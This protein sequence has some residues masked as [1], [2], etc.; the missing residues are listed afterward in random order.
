MGAGRAGFGGVKGLSLPAGPGASPSGSKLDN[1]QHHPARPPWRD[2][3]RALA[4]LLLLLSGATGWMYGAGGPPAD[5]GPARTGGPIV[6]PAQATAE[7]GLWIG[8]DLAAEVPE[9]LS[10]LTPSA[11]TDDAPEAGGS[12]PSPSA[13]DDAATKA[14][15]VEHRVA[16][17][18]T[19]WDIART[20]GTDVTS[21]YRSNPLRRA[22]LIRPG[23]VLTVPTMKGV[24]HR[25]ERSETLWEIARLY[26][27]TTDAIAQAN[28]LGD[29]GRIRPGQLL[30]IPGVSGPRYERLVVGGRLQR[31]LRWPVRGRI[32]S[33]FGRRWGRL[34]QG[35]DIAVPRHTPV[36]AAA[37]GRVTFARWGGGYGYLVEVDHGSGVVTRYAHSARILVR[38]GQSVAAGQVLALS[39]NTGHSTGPHL[40]FEIRYRGRAVN[41]LPYLR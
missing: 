37:P 27:V 33:H 3:R 5:P 29:P 7:G 32:T 36:R 2:I 23:Q 14:P 12:E 22:D 24:V 26:G 13:T 35:I 1:P 15:F 11:P 8:A 30:V 40:H 16:P 28:G 17:G 10:A 41:P 4:A 31:A 39:G 18:E 21:I 19:L 38:E 20:Y 25:V 34:H 6:A 9:Y